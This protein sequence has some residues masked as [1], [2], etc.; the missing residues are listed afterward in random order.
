MVLSPKDTLDATS[1]QLAAGTFFFFILVYHHIDS[2]CTEYKQPTWGA[3]RFGI[4]RVSP[5]PPKLPNAQAPNTERERAWDTRPSETRGCG[6][7]REFYR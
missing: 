1:P 3:R 2:Q 7:I 6:G 5:G 4:A